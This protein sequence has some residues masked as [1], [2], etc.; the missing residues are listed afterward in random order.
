MQVERVA[1]E[2]WKSLDQVVMKHL[3]KVYEFALEANKSPL[4]A[5]ERVK[6]IGV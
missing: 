6:H 3:A 4:S 5:S 1:V 2:R